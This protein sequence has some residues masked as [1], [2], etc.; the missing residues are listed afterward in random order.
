MKELIFFMGRSVCHQLPE[1]SFFI[2]NNQMPLCARCTGIYIGIF[3]GF[4]YLLLRKRWKGNKPPS[5][6]MLLS[7]IVFWIPMMVDGITSYI[8]LRESNNTIRLLTGLLFG[9]FLPVFIILLKNFQV[10]S[11]NSIPIISY[12]DL[13]LMLCILLFS[14]YMFTKN[15]NTI[16]WIISLISV[17]TILYVYVQMFIIIIRQISSSI[18][19]NII[20][21]M[22]FIIS[23]SMMSG[24]SWINKIIFAQYR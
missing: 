9:I 12:K 8:G 17:F 23:I 20:Y 18:N 13:L 19:I 10:S 5:L 6:K 1:R 16:W 11:R 4:F 21:C 24:L 2:Q 3:L 14:T 22:A 7:I 15:F